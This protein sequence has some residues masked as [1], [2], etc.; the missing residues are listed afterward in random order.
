MAYRAPID[1]LLFAMRRAAGETGFAPGGL[2][3][4]LDEST[5]RATLEEASKFAENAL[6]PLDRAGD[7]AG[8]RLSDGE[9]T[10]APGWR[11]AYR[12]WV[13]GGWNA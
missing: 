5:A 8:L 7:R 6:L 11:D 2:Y 1:D 13:E 10:T 12:Q 4:D 3:A 9:V